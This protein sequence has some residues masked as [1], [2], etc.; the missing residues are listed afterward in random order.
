MDFSDILND[1][2]V[3]TQKLELAL[4]SQI[5]EPT[6][7]NKE[8]GLLFDK[9]KLS[10]KKVMNVFFAIV[11]AKDMKCEDKVTVVK[12]LKEGFGLTK[13]DA[14]SYDNYALRV[15]AANGHL[16]VVKYLKDAFEVEDDIQ[17]KFD[18]NV[19]V[20]DIVKLFERE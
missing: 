12:Y 11:V 3:I 15:S 16:D 6:G 10:K 8:L 19:F 13:E 7:V 2:K 9:V 17:D 5:E 1:S 20:K 14:Q 4:Q 18:V